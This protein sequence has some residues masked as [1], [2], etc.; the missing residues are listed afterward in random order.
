MWGY[1]SRSVDCGDTY[2]KPIKIA[3]EKHKK[4]ENDGDMTY[5]NMIKKEEKV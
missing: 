5:N 4:V 2:W 3:N 1:R